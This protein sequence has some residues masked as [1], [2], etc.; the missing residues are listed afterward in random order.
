MKAD[1]VT[2][3]G[4]FSGAAPKKNGERSPGLSGVAAPDTPGLARRAGAV[5][6]SSRFAGAGAR[7]APSLRIQRWSVR[8]LRCLIPQKFRRRFFLGMSPPVSHG[9]AC[10]VGAGA[11]CPSPWAPGMHGPR[12]SGSRAAEGRAQR[13]LDVERGRCDPGDALPQERSPA[14]AASASERSSPRTGG[15]AALRAGPEALRF[16]PVSHQPF[17]RSQ[18]PGRLATCTTP[19]RGRGTGVLSAGPGCPVIATTGLATPCGSPVGVTRA[20]PTA[21]A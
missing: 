3:V 16:T 2:G 17:S 10:P 5:R 1:T 13:S 9:S 21:G 20:G 7:P 15:F 18:P 19:T 8:S 11:A 14:G 12:G 4:G 6:A